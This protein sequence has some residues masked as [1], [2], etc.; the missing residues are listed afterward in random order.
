MTPTQMAAKFH[1]ARDIWRNL[2]GERWRLE[3]RYY[4]EQ[5]GRLMQSQNIDEIKAVMRIGSRLREINA[6]DQFT[7]W[8]AAVSVM[9]EPG[10]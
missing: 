1:D 2:H 9:L 8:L 10:P 5:L 6:I 7:P 4:V 3:L